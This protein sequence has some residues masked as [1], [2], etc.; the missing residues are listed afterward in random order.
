MSS[1][2]HYFMRYKMS[3]SVEEELIS[4]IREKMVENRLFRSKSHVVE[5]ALRYFFNG[6]AP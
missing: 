1:I 2:T 4:K 6:G 5:E 3:I